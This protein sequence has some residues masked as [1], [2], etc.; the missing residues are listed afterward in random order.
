MLSD[1]QG[2]LWVVGLRTIVNLKLDFSL[3]F[4][5]S[6]VDLYYFHNVK[7]TT[8]FSSILKWCLLPLCNFL[9]PLLD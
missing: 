6:T 2:Y 1:N 9:Q 7:N 8:T 3:V 4:S 5:Y